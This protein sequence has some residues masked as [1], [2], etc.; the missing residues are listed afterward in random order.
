MLRKE[1]TKNDIQTGDP[2]LR[3]FTASSS[4]HQYIAG[5]IKWLVSR[6]FSVLGPINPILLHWL[7]RTC[8]TMKPPSPAA[9]RESSTALLQA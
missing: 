1:I 2:I 7:H 5:S 6:Q 3:I 8:I 4:S 9:A